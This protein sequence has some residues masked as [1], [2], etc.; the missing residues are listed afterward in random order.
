MGEEMG[1]VE[2]VGRGV[3]GVVAPAGGGYTGSIASR[4]MS[5]IIR[6]NKS[7]ETTPLIH[8]GGI[9]V[10]LRLSAYRAKGSGRPS[11]GLCS[12]QSAKFENLH[13][14]GKNHKRCVKAMQ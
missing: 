9:W 13:P 6:F 3:G 1:T 5:S 2:A 8:T 12:L 10:S 4:I 11:T 7:P 14:T